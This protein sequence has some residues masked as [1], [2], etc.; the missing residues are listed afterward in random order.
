MYRV[1]ATRDWTDNQKTADKD[2][3]LPSNAKFTAPGDVSCR[4]R[5]CIAACVGQARVAQSVCAAF[6][7]ICNSPWIRRSLHV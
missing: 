3:V 6:P 4:E 2:P 1:N 5:E 7:R